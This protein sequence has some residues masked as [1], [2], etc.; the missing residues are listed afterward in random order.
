MTLR[1]ELLSLVEEVLRGT[2]EGGS[3]E[4]DVIGEA[5]GVRSITAEEIDAILA[6]IEKRGRTIVTGAG[7]GGEA[8]LKTVLTTAR[9]LRVELG[10]TPNGNQIAER[11]GLALIDVQH[12]L[13]LARIIQR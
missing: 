2:K 13:A 12:A 10:H 11:S 5:I 8:T 9:T 7:G 1:A 6:T 4:L 3:V